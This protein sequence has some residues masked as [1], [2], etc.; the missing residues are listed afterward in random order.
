MVKTQ[1]DYTVNPSVRLSVY[2]NTYRFLPV[3]RK[4]TK[5]RKEAWTGVNAG[6]RAIRLGMVTDKNEQIKT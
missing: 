1:C 2:S 5:G 6:T 3:K 4:K